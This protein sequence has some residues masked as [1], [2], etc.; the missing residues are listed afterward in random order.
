MSA[1]GMPEWVPL[2]QLRSKVVEAFGEAGADAAVITVL[3]AMEADVVSVRWAKDFRSW[4][5]V[6]REMGRQLAISSGAQSDGLV[7]PMRHPAFPAYTFDAV[8]GIAL[9]TA[10]TDSDD[11]PP[12]AAPRQPGPLPVG[13]VDVAWHLAAALLDKQPQTQRGAE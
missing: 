4:R 2:R 6:E 12:A 13:P 5:L 3:A 10:P 7:K 8:E 11:D 1:P 9:A